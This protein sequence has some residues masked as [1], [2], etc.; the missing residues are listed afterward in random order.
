[1][2]RCPEVEVE[3][4]GV[5]GGFLFGECFDLAAADSALFTSVVFLDVDGHFDN[6][7]WF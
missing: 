4:G 3:A 7:S 5:F 6:G 2:A 1:M